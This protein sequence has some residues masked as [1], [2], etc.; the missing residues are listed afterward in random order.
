MIFLLSPKPR[1]PLPVCLQLPSLL[2]APSLSPLLFSTSS[3]LHAALPPAP[4]AGFLLL[5]FSIFLTRRLLPS[6]VPSLPS[7]WLCLPPG[8]G[9]LG[10]PLAPG[11]LFFSPSW[12]VFPLQH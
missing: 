3:S 12:A 10:C 2:P 5:F 6:S 9:L 11:L 4:F 8:L 7:F 1:L